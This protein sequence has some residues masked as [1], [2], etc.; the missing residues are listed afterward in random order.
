MLG[1][2]M[3]TADSSRDQA[4]TVFQ[5]HQPWLFNWLLKKLGCPY[6]AGDIS[7]DTF[8]NLLRAEHQP[9]REPRAYLLVIANRLMINRHRRQK[10]EK[11]VLEH[12]FVH[13]DQAEHRGPAE[14]TIHRQLLHQALLVLTEEVPEKHRKAFFMARMDGMSYKAIAAELK[15]SESSIK[16]YMARTLVHCHQRLYGETTP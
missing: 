8:L 12:L 1:G 16:Q 15:V 11:E 14:I 2:N 3:A 13:G 10:V 4:Q 5:S 6:D 7:Q 9:L